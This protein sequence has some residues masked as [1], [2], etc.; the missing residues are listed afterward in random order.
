VKLHNLSI[1]QVALGFN[2]NYPDYY[3]MIIAKSLEYV[4]INL[5]T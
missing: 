2:I 4:T 1:R 5:E 3:C